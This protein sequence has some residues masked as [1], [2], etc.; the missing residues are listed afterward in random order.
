MAMGDDPVNG[1]LFGKIDAANQVHEQGGTWSTEQRALEP[2]QPSVLTQSRLVLLS[3]ERAVEKPVEYK[4]SRANEI[5]AREAAAEAERAA[6]KAAKKQRKEDR[7]QAIAG[8]DAR[9]KQQERQNGL[10]WVDG[11]ATCFAF[12]R[13]LSP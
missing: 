13:T 5:A 4:N 10:L 12:V 8:T 7:A 2:L 1:M 11:V 3:Q 6:K 9:I